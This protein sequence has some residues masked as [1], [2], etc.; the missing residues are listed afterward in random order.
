MKK[1]RNGF[2]LADDIGLRLARETLTT[3]EVAF[4][5]GSYCRNVMSGEGY[6]V[7]MR[8]IAAK[9]KAYADHAEAEYKANP[10]RYEVTVGG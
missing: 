9:I 6:V 10:R 5:V 4:V 1:A 3:Q 2:E 8:E 7:M